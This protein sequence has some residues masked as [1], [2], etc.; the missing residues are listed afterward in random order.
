M[1]FAVCPK[2]DGMVTFLFV[3]FGAEFE[4]F[5]CSILADFSF[6]FPAEKIKD[7]KVK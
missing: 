5:F 7:R 3:Q 6:S 2:F 4:L 1:C